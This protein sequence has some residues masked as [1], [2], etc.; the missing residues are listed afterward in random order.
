NET[1]LG[2]REYA[3][4]GALALDGGA[5]GVFDRS[6]VEARDGLEL[7]ERDD[8]GTAPCV[9]ETRRQ[10][11][12]LLRQARYVAI[13]P[14]IRKRDR[15]TR[16]ASAGGREGSR[17]QIGPDL[18]ERRRN[19]VAQP[20]ARP[21][22]PGFCGRERARIALEKRD[23]RAEAAG[24][25]V[26]GEHAA[27]GHGGQRQADQRRLAVTARRDEKHFLR[28]GEV[29]DEAVEL[30]NPIGERGR[31]H[32]LAVHERILCYVKQRNGY[33]V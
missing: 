29:A 6:A 16:R 33:V 10:R 13:G 23:I 31:G 22:R 11:E 20:C 21:L 30:D 14:R 8:D 25:D 3:A 27:A 19:G 15:R 9:G 12:H 26:D 32:D 1:G 24:G 4:H 18:D 17:A 28:R 7:V 5:Q 2:S